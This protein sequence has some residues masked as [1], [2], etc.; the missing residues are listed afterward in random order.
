[1]E[2]LD[3]LVELDTLNLSD[4]MVTKIKGIGHLSKLVSLYLANNKIQSKDD[5]LALVECPSIQ[6]LKKSII[7]NVFKISQKN[8]GYFQKFA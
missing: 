5:I 3:S 4:N 6:Y 1:M 2:N 7:P 8:F